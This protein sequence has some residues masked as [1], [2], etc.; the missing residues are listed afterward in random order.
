MVEDGLQRAA[1]LGHVGRQI[2]QFPVT[3]IAD[4]EALTGV[5]HAQAFRHIV[6]RRIDAP[7]P[8]LETMNNDKAGHGHGDHRCGDGADQRRHHPGEAEPDANGKIQAKQREARGKAGDPD[9]G[10]RPPVGAVC[11]AG[12]GV[13][14]GVCHDRRL[15]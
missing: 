2:V 3:L 12:V 14:V 9:H 10:D 8:A 13:C 1:A 5:E 6:E 4:E 15:A 7:V 11:G